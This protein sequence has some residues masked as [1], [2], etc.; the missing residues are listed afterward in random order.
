M[1]QSAN[2]QLNKV[3]EGKDGWLFLGNDSNNSVDQYT[4]KLLL[5]KD[6]V[7]NYGAYFSN[8]NSHI[9]CDFSFFIVPNKEYV[10]SEFYP[11]FNSISKGLTILEQVRG[12]A[13]ANSVEINYP[14]EL[15]TSNPES[16]YKTD[17]HWNDFGAYLGL[18]S[19]FKYMDSFIFP[20]IDLESFGCVYVSG[21]LGEK[22]TPVKKD[23]RLVYN[24]ETEAEVVFNS[25]L[26]NHGYLIH[27]KNRN[28]I[29]KKKVLIFGD[30]FGIQFEKFLKVVFSEVIF[31]YSPA[32]FVKD[33]Y[34]TVSPDFVILQ[35]N[36]RFL[37]EPPK[38]RFTMK[39]SLIFKKIDKFSPD[40]FTLWKKISR[41]NVKNLKLQNCFCLIWVRN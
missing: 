38:F 36:Q 27:Y 1:N 5:S 14:I 16:F 40:E 21:D 7:S 29:N 20:K 19:I 22:L 24:A 4:G 2:E 10:L 35:I 26:K 9:K 8:L 39:N 25:F 31:V 28:A 33:I 18:L 11:Y 34:D 37:V 17:T 30:S 15:L 3:I 13:S 32:V 41:I 12:V 23:K 6:C